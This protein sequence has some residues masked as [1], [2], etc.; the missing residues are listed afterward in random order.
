MPA[1]CAA[2]TPSASKYDRTTT[3]F[4]KPRSAGETRMSVAFSSTAT[5]S[6]PGVAPS[7][8]AAGPPQADSG[9]TA[10]SMSPANSPA[11]ASRADSASG[12]AGSSRGARRKLAN[13]Q[14]RKVWPSS[15]AQARGATAGSASRGSSPGACAQGIFSSCTTRWL[16]MASAPPTASTPPPS[17]YACSI[18]G[19]SSSGKRATRAIAVQPPSSASRRAPRSTVPGSST[20]PQEA[21]P[22]DMRSVTPMG[23]SV[24]A[25]SATSTPSVARAARAACTCRRRMSSSMAASSSSPIL[26]LPRTTG[27]SPQFPLAT[28]SRA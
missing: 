1:R 26:L 4:S 13:T 21:P 15:S 25:Y 20:A 12:G 19:S 10:A 6:A 3:A 11:A 23:A 28:S 18:A 24:T 7:A 5:T 8:K 27:S 9:R 17:R 14:G 22:G 2:T 16:K